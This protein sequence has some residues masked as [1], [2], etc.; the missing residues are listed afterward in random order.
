[1]F[2]PLMVWY[3]TDGITDL[4]IRDI[5]KA[6]SQL[7]AID[8]KIGYEG[9]DGSANTEIRRSQVK[10]ILRD[11]QPHLVDVAYSFSRAANK[12][13]F[14]VDIT[15]LPML[16]YSIYDSRDQG[17]YDWHADVFWS[18]S[19][20]SDRKLSIVIQI[21]DGDDYE[22]GDLELEVGMEML[23][24]ARFRQKGSVIVFPSVYHHRVTPV[25]K[26]VR[27]SLVGWIEGPP[28]R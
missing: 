21:T 8:A 4:Y 26:G 7:P 16:Q 13:C 12:E 3:G 10:W 22:G 15:D 24:S 14:G 28:W 11:E 9:G 18:D 27:K 2:K 25:T 17:Y 5:E 6:A 1:M 19:K 20:P 23:D